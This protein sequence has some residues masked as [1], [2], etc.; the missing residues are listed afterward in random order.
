MC[1]HCLVPIS[2]AHLADDERGELQCFQIILYQV[3]VFLHPLPEL[4][5]L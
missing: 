2:S 4:L 3:W 5:A 1:N